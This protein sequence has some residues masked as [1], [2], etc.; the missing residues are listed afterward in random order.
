MPAIPWIPGR[1]MRMLAF[2]ASLKS[3]MSSAGL[4]RVLSYGWHLRFQETLQGREGVVAPPAVGPS[5]DDF[6]CSDQQLLQSKYVSSVIA[7]DPNRFNDELF[8]CLP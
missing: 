2:A 8:C 4:M 6:T 3:G 1:G 7:S 5:P